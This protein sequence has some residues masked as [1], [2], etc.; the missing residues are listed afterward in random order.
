MIYLLHFDRALGDP[1]NPRGQA[2][3]Y[4]GWCAGDVGNRLAEHRAGRG[5]AITAY[6]VDQGIGWQLV[7]LWVGNGHLEQRIKR[8]HDAPQLCPICNP[9]GWHRRANYSANWQPGLAVEFEPI[10]ALATAPAGCP[11]WVARSQASPKQV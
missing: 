9:D 1:D 7:R 6:L 3:H 2:Q 5:A 11:L 8:R 10:E 4:I